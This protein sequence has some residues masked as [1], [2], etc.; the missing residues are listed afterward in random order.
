M[1]HAQRALNDALIK[2]DD[3]DRGTQAVA[4]SS[5]SAISTATASR[6][7]TGS[8]ASSKISAIGGSIPPVPKYGTQYSAVGASPNRVPSVIKCNPFDDAMSYVSGVK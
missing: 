4:Q 5:A 7:V 1:L 6:R 8:D 3:W 2:L